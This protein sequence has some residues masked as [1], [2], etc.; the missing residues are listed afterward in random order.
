MVR[1]KRT[2]RSFSALLFLVALSATSV[3]SL[4][5]STHALALE[6][7]ALDRPL[8]ASLEAADLMAVGETSI[9]LAPQSQLDGIHQA[10]NTVI[11]LSGR[12]LPV[13][14]SVEGIAGLEASVEPGILAPGET[15]TI[16]LDGPVPAGVGTVTGT[17]NLYGFNQYVQIP[18]PVAVV[19]PV[20]SGSAVQPA[21][22]PGE[23]GGAVAVEAGVEG[24]VAVAAGTEGTGTDGAVAV[25]AGAVAAGT[26]GAGAGE[27]ATDGVGADGA[28]TDGAPPSA[29]G[30]ATDC[31]GGSTL[32]GSDVTPASEGDQGDGHPE[33]APVETAIDESTSPTLTDPA[34]PSSTEIGTDAAD[35]D[36]ILKPT[37][38]VVD[39]AA[40]TPPSAADAISSPVPFAPDTMPPA[41]APASNT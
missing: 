28:G 12:T 9:T 13:S 10:V 7:K 36:V 20:S 5:G 16:R 27:A 15:A 41:P 4:I 18:I 25:A 22:E 1:A 6:Q 32:V 38:A 3:S 31:D 14:V 23:C 11:N 2:G 17:L 30:A 39:G 8:F 33:G 37:E 29:E 21:P 26:D 24:T 34:T 40:I 35:A 19:L